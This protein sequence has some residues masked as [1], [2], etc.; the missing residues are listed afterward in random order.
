MSFKNPLPE[1]LNKLDSWLDKL[2]GVD[3]LYNQ[4]IVIG[5][6]KWMRPQRGEVP[7]QGTRGAVSDRANRVCKT[8]KSCR[9]QVAVKLG[10]GET[11]G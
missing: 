1:E 5:I 11:G 2:S 7:G 8:A 3:K 4:L 10:C 6:K 9:R